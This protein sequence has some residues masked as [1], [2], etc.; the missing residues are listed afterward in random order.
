MIARNAG[1]TIAHAG[2]RRMSYGMV[3]EGILE[4]LRMSLEYL[5]KFVKSMLELL[6]IASP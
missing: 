4:N 5:L 2:S 1:I 3:D 6:A